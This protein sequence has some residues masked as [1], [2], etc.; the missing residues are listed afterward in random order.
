MILSTTTDCSPESFSHVTVS[1]VAP[2][3]PVTRDEVLTLM[4][5]FLNE[6]ATTLPAST[7]VG[8][9]IRG[10]ASMIV[11]S[12][13]MSAS[14]DANSA[15]ITPPPM[16]ATRA[17]SSS[18]SSTWSDDSTRVPSKSRRGSER[19]YEPVAIT[20]LA[21]STSV[22]SASRTLCAAAST[23]S[24]RWSNTVTL[25][26]LSSVSR[27]LVSRSM[28]SRL[29]ACDRRRSSDGT[30]ASTPK[31]GARWIVRSTSAVCR[32]SL[33]GMQPRCR[34]V[35]PTRPSSTRATSRPAAAPYSAVAY[36]AGPPPRTTTSNCS[37]RTATSSS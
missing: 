8:A 24:P 21:P 33:A 31:S 5:R 2:S 6:R 9:R 34:H 35:P 14:I 10:S 36:P 29:R 11:T 27:P 30:P 28:T 12:L 4:P 15:P 13:P 16:M 20:R 25:R 3:M 26:P 17:G 23:T 1:S 7:S 22:P 19:G 32:S 18:S 37:A